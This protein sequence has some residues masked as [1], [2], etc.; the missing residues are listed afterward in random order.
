MPAGRDDQA[1]FVRGFVQRVDAPHLRVQANHAI[2]RENGIAIRVDDE[3]RTRSHQR[4]HLR[5]IPAKCI[6]QEHAVAV[7]LDRAI[8]DMV[9]QIGDAGDRSR[10]LNAIIQRR[11]PPAVG[12]PSGTTG[13]PDSRGVYLGAG[14]QV[15]QSANAVPGLDPG[16][17]VAARVPPPLALIVSAVVGPLQFAQLQRV[18]NQ[19][20]ITI[21]G[22]PRPMMLVSDLV[23]V[24]HPILDHGAMPAQ[25]KNRR[26]GLGD[27][28]GKIEV[29]RYVEAGP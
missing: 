23:A 22:E 3:Q 25:V 8:H 2:E 11:D 21:P 29:R 12:S 1:K 19:A 10:C 24:T 15:I 16:G 6:H 5:I 17:R 7:A 28:P 14:L 20:N 9:F 18:Q 13:H 4:G 27:V 26:R